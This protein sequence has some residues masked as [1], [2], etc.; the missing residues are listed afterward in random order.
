V[1]TRPSSVAGPSSVV[2]A[3]PMHVKPPHNPPASHET[4]IV[5]A[6][7]RKRVVN[8]IGSSEANS[9]ALLDKNSIMPLEKIAP[10]TETRDLV[11]LRKRAIGI[12]EEEEEEEEE[13]EYPFDVDGVDAVRPVGIARPGLQPD[14]LRERQAARNKPRRAPSYR[15]RVVSGE[16]RGEASRVN[17]P[18]R[19]IKKPKR[20]KLSMNDGNPFFD[21]EAELSDEDGR[22]A[23]TRSDCD[24]DASMDHNLSGFIAESQQETQPGMET[25]Y[26]E[27]IQCP[28]VDEEEIKVSLAN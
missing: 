9:Q 24:Q 18:E 13:I 4:P 28:A 20:V 19:R 6:K 7:F 3:T 23:D 15:E 17:V 27:S 22:F 21:H 1:K 16:E 14:M 5:A 8:R 2:H 25:V 26:M 12:I 10:P 11:R